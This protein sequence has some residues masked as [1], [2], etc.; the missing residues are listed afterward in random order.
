MLNSGKEKPQE[1]ELL[2]SIHDLYNY[3]NSNQIDKNDNILIK[4]LKNINIL[5]ENKENILLF[6][7]ELSKQIKNG[8]NLILPFINPCYYLIEVYINN[9]YND[10]EWKEIFT[11]LIE[12]S[13]FNRNN[14]FP[15]YEYF[16]E[17]Y[18]DVDN[19][20]KSDDKLQKFSKMINL[21]NLLYS[22]SG[23]KNIKSFSTFCF[24][25]TGL[26]ISGLDSFPEYR[27]LDIKIIFVNN[28]PLKYLDKNDDLCCTDFDHIKY[29]DISNFPDINSINFRFKDRFVELIINK[30]ISGNEK[31]YSRDLKL[32]SS[33]KNLTI[34]NNFYGEIKSIEISIFKDIPNE[35]EEK[36]LYSKQIN[37]FPLK[38]NYILFFSNY[39]FFV[40]NNKNKNQKQ[41]FH[42]STIEIKVKDINLLK[43]NYI[44]YKEENNIIDYFGGIIQFLPFLKIING[45]NRNEKIL[46]INDSDKDIILIDFIKNIL[47]II[48]NYLIKS[49]KINI[50]KKYWNFF[51]H[52]FNKIELFSSEK[53]KINIEE[54][55][56]LL[57]ASNKTNNIF[58]IFYNF[59]VYINSK[60]DKN[61]KE[62]FIASIMSMYLTENNKGN[63]NYINSFEKTNNQLYR[64]I[65]KQLFV[66]NRLWSKQHLFFKNVFNCYK[67]K[68]EDLKIKYKRI[69][70]YT[71]NFQQPLIYPILEVDK[72]YPNFKKFKVKDL[73]KNEN[74]KDKILKYDFSLNKFNNVLTQQDID[75]YLDN[76]KCSE[77]IK[78]CL[79]KKMYH[80]K[81]EI[82]ILTSDNNKDNFKIIFSSSNEEYKEKCNINNENDKIDNNNDLCY[83]SVFSCLEKDRKRLISI[84]KDNIMFVIKRIY[85]YRPSGLEIF[86]FNNK[87]YY[88]NFFED[89]I[90]H[91]NKIIEYCEKNFEKIQCNKNKNDYIGWY[92]PKYS[93]VLNPLFNGNIDDW[94]DKN[95][96]Y[97]NFDKL[98]IINLF[99]NRSF[100]D[101]YQYPVFPMLYNEIEKTRKMKEPIG[102]QE[103]TEESKDRKQL[104]IDSYCY[105]EGDTESDTND[106]YYFNLFYSN[107]TYT[108]NYLIRVLPYSFIGIEYQ[109]DGFDDPNRLFSSIN[110]TFLNTLNQRA[111]LR[112]LIPE[113]FYFPPLFYN[114]NDLKFGKISNGKEIDK[115]II[116][117][118]DENEKRK[119][120]FL[121]DMKDYLEKEEDLHLWIDLIFGINK[122]Q[123]EKGERYYN[124]NS[125]IE[126]KNNPQILTNTLV[127]QSYDFGVLPFQ[128]LKINFPKKEKYKELNKKLEINKYNEYLFNEEHIEC[129]IDGKI[130]FICKGEKDINFKYLEII[131]NYKKKPFFSFLERKKED[132]N[133]N[134]KNKNIHFSYLFTGDV[135]GNLSVYKKI[136][137]NTSSNNNKEEINEVRYDNNLL[138]EIKNNYNLMKILTDHS[139]EIKY[140]DY[141]PR[142]NLLVDYALDGFINLYTMPTLKLILS[143]Q[144][145]DFGIKESV[146]Y[147]LLIS[148]PFP[149][150]CCITFSKT[151]LFDINGK[152]INELNIKEGQKISV[153]IDKNCG[154]YND[155][156]SCLLEDKTNKSVF[157]FN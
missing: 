93:R 129:L 110:S 58:S 78:C 114:I 15:I 151:L 107:I 51:L 133:K 142:L 125:N 47:L 106:K 87:S 72:F 134:E 127:L 65:M 77:A 11:L 111:D 128:L 103:I 124:E 55:K 82:F 5:K 130:S 157:I 97:S 16:T 112:E 30:D 105:A 19:L 135:L 120:K 140:I 22:Y 119:Y 137:N 44:N 100:N 33:I 132:I 71:S 156:I 90:N 20:N 43:V 14:L 18:S 45:I 56:F 70:Y 1:F 101:L 9:D 8:N 63:I 53:T 38:N 28:N 155:N 85:Y 61:A 146:I 27:Y 2:K 150:I 34:L 109:G 60:K 89:F 153:C 123:N 95:Y 143:I 118:W 96:Y 108:C 136:N 117:N 40:I 26:E 75:N 138:I 84:P 126:F 31:G 21:W 121:N 35:R 17:L 91:H 6:I 4:F 41:I 67:N 46:K 50:F 104:I 64:N 37:P 42:P 115:I 145:L 13:F 66:Y 149:M 59:L 148:N 154:L 113:M 98:M 116:H 131:N 144:I 74:E 102:F 122:K 54:F 92:N 94:S 29:S 99:S 83:G 88:F 152:L 23:N 7:N 12:N 52:I 68:N 36:Y 39:T 3:K 81:G 57:N 24:M 48:F 49:D 62:S 25:G 69:N 147:V 80:V 139:N 73:Y 86:T 79:I 32:S 10:I 76:N 141:N